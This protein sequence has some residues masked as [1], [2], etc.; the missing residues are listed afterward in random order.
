MPI[1]MTGFARKQIQASWGNLSCELRSVN[2]RYLELNFRLPDQL[3]DLEMFLRDQLRKNLE[4]GKIDISFRL[5]L[6]ASSVDTLKINHA[7]LDQ[8]IG[9]TETIAEKFGKSNSL[10]SLQV[11]QW[12][13]VLEQAQ[14]D[15]TV[16]QQAAS[17]L[18]EDALQA[19]QAMRQREGIELAEYIRTRLTMMTQEAEKIGQALPLLL[20]KQRQR[21]QD[22]FA[23]FKL[24]LDPE[25]LEQEMLIL[26]QKADISEELDRLKTHIAEVDRVLKS[27]TS[28]GRRLD[29][30]MQELNREVNTIGSKSVG[31]EITQSVVDLKVAIE[32][33]REQVQNIE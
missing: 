33:M 10:N 32:Q 2:H 3:R 1:S 6:E 19:L 9:A 16:I 21:L 7:V 4:R 28:I 18:L 11:L 15:E 29:F 22:K 24:E 14:T 31:M 20:Q 12:P 13:G 17:K 23:E 5:Q 30:L 25:R 8:L 27:S 26:F